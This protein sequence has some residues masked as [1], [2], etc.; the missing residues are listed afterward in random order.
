ML[1]DDYIGYLTVLQTVRTCMTVC[2]LTGFSVPEA[3]RAEFKNKVAVIRKSPKSQVYQIGQFIH[4]LDVS[5]GSTGMT[6]Q[7]KNMCYEFV[8][9]A[10]DFILILL[11]FK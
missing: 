2:Y 11:L 6:K 8:Q 9:C 3:M 10:V 1:R 7:R 4:C 5:I